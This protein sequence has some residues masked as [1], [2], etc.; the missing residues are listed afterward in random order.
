MSR[1][2]KIFEIAIFILPIHFKCM[3]EIRMDNFVDTSSKVDGEPGVH[4]LSETAKLS[5]ALY[6]VTILYVFFH[7]IN[8]VPNSIRSRCKISESKK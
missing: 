4:Q 5:Y 3:Y 8:M 2:L 6:K 1:D 7:I